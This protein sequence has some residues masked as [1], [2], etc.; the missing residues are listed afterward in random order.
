MTDLKA[1]A[2]TSAKLI[3]T[4]EALGHKF[5]ERA[6][7]ADRNRRLSD[8]TVRE[9]ID[10]GLFRALQPAR[11]GG[12]ETDLGTF[13]RIAIALAQGD[14]S[15]SWVYSVL[16]I[17]NW[18]LGLAEPELQEEIWGEDQSVLFADSFPTLATAVRVDGGYRLSGTW[19]FV[20]GIEWSEYVALGALASPE[21]GGP[22]EHF[23][24]FLPRSL[25]TVLDE[26]F[27]L[28]LRG[29]ASNT[30]V[31]DDAFIPDY[32]AFPLQRVIET[33]VA[34]GHAINESPLFRL[35]FTATLGS[36]LVPSAIGG[37]RAALEYFRE[38]VQK[39][40]LMLEQRQQKESGSAHLTLAECTASVDAAETLL[41]RY[42]DELMTAAVSGTAPSEDAG[43]RYFAWRA[44][45]TQECLRVVDRV[46][47]SSGG[48]AIFDD[49]PLQRVLRDVHALAQHS[50]LNPAISMSAFG[51]TLLGM[52][53]GITGA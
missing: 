3:S 30:V 23:M 20:S 48:F 2:S 7:E 43:V 28:G 8:E 6:P 21:D 52:D 51:R 17:H 46:F 53:S 19:K 12:H 26:W 9:L 4:A 36:V 40:Y 49:H 47:T 34:P 38:S 32:R 14:V 22:P 10:S 13:L 41:M 29:T 27:V 11:Y 45:I 15:A 25:Y 50:Q 37:A 42:A 31:V 35:P 44:H 16:G 1:Q 18:F 24:M 5:R 39:R 33:G